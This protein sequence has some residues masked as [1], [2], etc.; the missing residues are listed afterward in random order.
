ME[1]KNRIPVLL[2]WV[3][4]ISFILSACATPTQAPQVAE[5]AEPTESVAEPT[6]PPAEATEPAEV[7]PTTAPPEVAPT[8]APVEPLPAETGAF[9]VFNR[10]SDCTPTEGGDANVFMTDFWQS[11]ISIW[12]TTAWINAKRL[13]FNTLLTHTDPTLTEF[14]PELAESWTLSP[15][16]R[17]ATF[18]LRE[19][20]KWH[21]GEPFTA[22][23]VEYS[24]KA[25][26]HPDS[27]STVG[28]TLRL[29]ELVGAQDFME[30]KTDQIEGV[31]VLDDYTIELTTDAPVGF[32][33][34]LTTMIIVPEHI[35][36]DVPYKDLETNPFTQNWIGTGPFKFVQWVPGQFVEF[37]RFDDYWGGK[38]YLD[39]IINIEY[40]DQATAALAFEKGEVDLV[41]K[42]TGP[43]LERLRNLPN[44]MLVGAPV[45]FANA[46]AFNFQ[47]PYLQ[48]KRVRQAMMYAIDNQAIKEGLY[49]DTIQLT[50]APLPHPLWANQDLVNAYPYDPEKAKALLAEANWDPNQ[51]IDLSTYYSDQTVTNQLT[52][53]QQNWADV[54]IKSEIRLLES[55]SVFDTWINGDFDVTYIGAQGSADPDLM[56]VFLGCETTPENGY[57]SFGNNF[58]RYCN[59]EVD[60]L[61]EEARNTADYDERKAIYDEIQV[62]LSDEVAYG[63]VWV[64]I[65]LAAMRDWIIN[66]NWAQDF[67]DGD[68][69][70]AYG[71]WFLSK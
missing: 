23:D 18:K 25:Y 43:D 69:D 41:M 1:T 28:P 47:K 54:G 63:P 21:D 44:T 34:N 45:D 39:R 31:K 6:E 60:A 70:Q 64:P 58:W 35:L 29:D 42:V 32:L 53:V 49:G 61:F 57:V 7:E 5:S 37:A 4:I 22:K 62:I 59:P 11:N 48:D 17:T 14:K 36:G 26:I 3:L 51:V 40:K 38:P 68:Y 20:V 16:G 2:V 24:I 9:P 55:A 65:R 50:N 27:G 67:A 8:E 12:K 30:G 56:S 66:G 13:A 33:F 52:A 10:C 71:T 15:D 46:Y 19:G